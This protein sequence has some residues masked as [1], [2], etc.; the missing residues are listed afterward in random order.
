MSTTRHESVPE[1]WLEERDVPFF[2]LTARF[3]SP[4]FLAG[5]SVL[6]ASY[7]P[8][9][10]PTSLNAGQQTVRTTSTQAATVAT[11]AASAE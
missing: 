8:D 11:S 1:L 6:L 7:D 9:E 5:A 3:F 4:A 2:K 10:V